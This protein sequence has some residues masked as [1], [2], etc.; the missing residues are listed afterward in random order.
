MTYKK[1]DF[2]G[3]VVS[4]N[5]KDKNVGSALS[6][7]N[8]PKDVELFKIDEG[9]E[10]VLLD[11]VPYIVSD[12]HHPCR[13][14]GSDIAT[15]GTI[16]WRRPF[17]IHRGIGANNETV[18]CPS[19][20]GKKCP[21]CEYQLK[22]FKDKGPTDE[23]KALRA[24]NRDLYIVI[25]IES[26]KH[27]EV[28]YIMDMARKNFQDILAAD[29]KL[30]P[31]NELFFTPD[32]GKTAE[33][34]FIWESLGDVNYPKA[35]AFS[36]SP[37]QPYDDT[38]LEQVPDLDKVLK[39]KTYDELYTMFYQVDTESDGG[40][41]R[42]VK[43][44][45]PIRERKSLRERGSEDN[46]DREKDNKEEG[47][48]SV[49]KEVSDDKEP[50]ERRRHQPEEKAEDVKTDR[51]RI[52]RRDAPDK[53]EENVPERRTRRDSASENAEKSATIGR[54]LRE[55][56]GDAKKAGKDEEKCPFGHR[57]GVDTAEFKDCD[58]CEI[59]D[60]CD[61]ELIKRKRA[62]AK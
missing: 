47:R 37:R 54:G 32:E 40:D 10:L 26:K 55:E 2:R 23:T 22:L 59:Y 30:K 31:K 39:I 50:V 25:P 14:E 57:F 33:V 13:E 1:I 49:R 35:R 62:S 48:R 16:W 4:N 11:I 24:K 38:L 36:F 8:L 29:L 5:D 41:L 21:I 60:D 15:P 19:S 53:A 6:Y 46:V 9:V 18:V 45:E 58:S 34:T 42:D 52:S 27:D 20:M 7:L 3:K 51:Q 61:E 28:P 44:D 12:P 56:K 43:S 17:A